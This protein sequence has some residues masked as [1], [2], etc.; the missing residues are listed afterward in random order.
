MA[1]RTTKKKTAFV[2]RALVRV[3]VV[4]SVIPA[5]AIACSSG[6]TGSVSD[7]GPD[8]VVYGVAAVAYPAYEAG[9]KDTGLG[10]VKTD[11]PDVQTQDVGIPP[12]VAAVAYPAYEAGIG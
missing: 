6:G 9:G 2:P 4:A 11:V 10:D 7:A 12:G 3:T 8:R 5:C 1:R